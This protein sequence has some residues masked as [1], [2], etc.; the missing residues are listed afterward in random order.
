MRRTRESL[1]ALPPLCTDGAWGTELMKLGGTPGELKDSWN[2]SAPDKV[3]KVARSYVEAGARIIL[4][5]TFSA[6]R[7]VL[8]G[9]GAAG[10][11]A[12]INRAG[13]EISRRAAE[14][15]AYVFASLGPTGKLVSAGEIDPAAAEEAFAEQAAA[16]AAGGADA[17]CVETLT[18]IEEARA[19]LR[20]CLRACALPAGITFT[21]DSGR[22]KDRTMMGATIEQACEMA[23]AE[24]AGFVGANCGL[25][26]EAYV[27]LARRFAACAKDLPIWIKGNAGRPEVGPDGRTVYKAAPE[28]FAAA[29]EPLLGAGV[30]FMGGCC[31]STPDHIR[32][33]AAALARHVR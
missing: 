18:D 6:N 20:G 13:A 10:R 22:D 2:V 28:A 21:F 33:M 31:G 19:A 12:E 26:I 5:N 24:G 7:V 3:L 30:R 8:E 32:A 1:K 15:K 25:G 16:L 14:G 9:H 17:L 23:R 29:V 27:P 11:A 4:T